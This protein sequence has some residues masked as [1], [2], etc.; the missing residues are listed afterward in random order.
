M[1]PPVSDSILNKDRSRTAH[2]Y[3]TQLGPEGAKLNSSDAPEVPE[4]RLHN[5]GL[6][7]PEEEIKPKTKLVKGEV[8][9]LVPE[10]VST[11][12]KAILT[13]I[14]REDYDVRLTYLRIWRKLQEY[15]KGI[16]D[17]YWD[18]V[19]T[20]WKSFSLDDG[21]TEPSRNINI[22]RAHMESVVA[23]LSIKVPGTTFFPDDA[24]NPLDIDTAEAY[25]AVADLIQKHNKFTLHIVRALYIFWTQGTV[26]AY[27]YY[28]MDPKFGTVEVPL[29]IEKQITTYD[30]SCDNCGY[31]L[32]T[33]KETA[34]TSPL[35]C[36]N[37]GYTKIPQVEAHSETIERIVGYETQAKG[38]EAVDFFGPI[39]CKVSFYARRQEDIGYLEHKLDSNTAMLKNEFP[40]FES[41]IGTGG[42][43]GE[44]SY[45]RDVRL[46]SEYR[47]DIPR[48]LA[49]VRSL[50]LRPWMY[51]HCSDEDV[52]NQ[53][54]EKYPDGLYLIYIDDT[55]VSI[56]NECLDDHW[57]ISI[58][59]LSDFIHNEPLGKPLVPVQEMRDDL[60]DLTFKTIEYGISEN[61][62]NPKVM[63]FQK[64]GDESASPGMFT[65]VTPVA[66]Q[67]IGDAFF[68]TSPAHLS[69]EVQSFGQQLDTDG[70]F[71]VGDFPSVYGGPSEGSKTAF[72]Y[73]KSNAQALQRL[74]L[75]WKRLVNLISDVTGKAVVEFVENMKTDERTVKKENGRF[76]NSWIRKQSLSG[77]IGSVEPE[78]S[79]QLPQT[80]EQKW[81]LI[82]NLLQMQDPAI[83]SV[84]EHPMNA[85]LMKQ[86]ISMP[87]FFIPGDHDRTKQFGEIYD[88]IANP[89]DPSV[90]VDF[91]MDD[92][93]IHMDVIKHFCTGMEGVQLYKTNPPVY[94]AFI[95][96]YKQHEMAEQQ[97]QMMMAPP[98]QGNEQP[99]P[100]GPQ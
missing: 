15:G 8:P 89:Q 62:A 100:A 1:F 45:E 50:W 54:F 97:K 39:N 11:A 96:H 34:P 9:E 80:W 73:D 26:F 82:T 18:E 91:D 83:N 76:I 92:H 86:A 60:T 84:L 16:Q 63:D 48:D 77:K 31:H 17:I 38:R 51:W 93:P 75:S 56:E 6:T 2:P 43:K 30:V 20:D 40:E 61:F 57:T 52:R 98:S 67:A 70:Q 23:A 28:R 5:N 27:N 29:K 58:D 78:T 85:H 10:E 37:C 24:D 44:D 32:G 13:K 35:R 12:L 33:V 14:E 22:F 64:Y 95:N 21:S 94:M 68:Q 19:A 87:Q 66:G 3:L 25:S 49:T 81:H 79:E 90:Q 46:A 74:S 47:G 72:E 71:V 41:R 53:L 55:L 42:S 7:L 65:P 99:Q 69:P 59:P 36:E 4:A 88:L